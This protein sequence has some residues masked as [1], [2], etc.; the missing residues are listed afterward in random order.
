VK[1]RGSVARVLVQ[2][3][4]RSW[5]G[6]PEPC[7]AIVDGRPVVAHTLA[8]LADAFPEASLAIVAP[9]FD[10]GG[11]FERLRESFRGREL[12]FCFGH[13]ADPLARLIDAT[14]DLDA[15][16]LVVRCD[17]QHCFADMELARRLVE[18]AAEGGFDCVKLPDD[19]PPALATEVYRVGALRRLAAALDPARDAAWRVHAKFAMCRRA[20]GFAYELMQPPHYETAQLERWRAEALRIHTAPRAEGD[21]HRRLRAGDQSLF[22]Y[23][24]AAPHLRPEWRVLEAACGDGAG[25]R[26]LAQRVAELTA[27]DL[28]ADQL[29]R[30]ASLRALRTPVRALAADVCHLP[31]PDKSFDAVTS[32]ETIEHTDPEAC[33]S[34][35]HRVLAPGGTL[36]LSTPQSSL[37]HVPLNPHH[38]REFS[39]DEFVA[40]AEAHFTVREVFG[41]K[42]GRILVPGDPIGTNTV[43]VCEKN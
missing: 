37:G 22:H 2:A 24:L 7:V 33:L 10:R 28:E 11:P 8:K 27:V 34:S 14:I 38:L 4:S 6:A 32:F 40:L 19:F 41:I 23:E 31:F 3:S 42:A 26:Y 43:L 29:P 20:S 21:D 16:A 36:V 25:T 39:L 30:L 1:L 12:R 13:D 9:A 15:D 18:R 17:G 5:K 35:F